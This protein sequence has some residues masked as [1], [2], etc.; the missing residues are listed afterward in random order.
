MPDK[1]PGKVVQ[2]TTGK[3]E[4]K[5]QNILIALCDD[6]SL[7]VTGIYKGGD[8]NALALW[9]PIMAP[10]KYYSPCVVG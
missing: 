10:A 5:D 9:E 8:G 3:F 6:G 7:Y 2:I 4:W 1:I